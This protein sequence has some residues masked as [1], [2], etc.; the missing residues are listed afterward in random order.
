MHHQA[1]Y[2]REAFNW[3]MSD[4][5]FFGVRRWRGELCGNIPC[6]IVCETLGLDL[7]MLR[8]LIWVKTSADL[9]KLRK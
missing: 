4:E 2:A 6:V 7:S 1:Q 8:R 3:I 5:E 9:E